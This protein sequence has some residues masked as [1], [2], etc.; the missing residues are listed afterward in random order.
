MLYLSYRPGPP[1][2]EFI[3]YLWLIEGGQS[4]RLEKILPCGASELVVNLKNNE[5]NI[6]DPQQP[7]RYRQLSG[8]VFSG[9]YSQSFI[10]DALQHESIMGVHFKP[11]GAFPFLDTHASELADAHANVADL[12]GRSGVELRER[13]CTAVTPQQR[14]RI[15]ADVLNSRLARNTA[16]DREMRFALEMFAM[17]N[18]SIREV[19]RELRVSHRRFIQMFS[20]HVGLAPKLF[21]R[22]LRFQRA[23][24]LAEKLEAPN[25][26]AVAVACGY[27]DQS[28]LIKDFKEFSGSTPGIYSVQQYH[29]DARLKDNHVLLR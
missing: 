2:N 4:P 5:I 22:I 23:R 20:S 16:R 21:C 27:F 25:W 26:A 9:A 12:W 13:L 10:C 6:H 18:T 1:L 19:S 15:M 7:E 17:R 29:R 11:G 28:H 3:D 14:F 8:A 24:V